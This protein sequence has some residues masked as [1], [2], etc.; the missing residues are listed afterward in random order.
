MITSESLQ[1]LADLKQN[2]IRDWFQANQHRY[3]LYKK[4][5]ARWPKLS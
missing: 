2:N 1:F 3:D 4:I 5:T